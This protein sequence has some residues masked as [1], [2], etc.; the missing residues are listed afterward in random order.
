MMLLHSM[1]DFLEIVLFFLIG[2]EVGKS[3]A[4]FLYMGVKAFFRRVYLSWRMIDTLR[5]FVN[6]VTV[7][8]VSLAMDYF[9]ENEIDD[10]GLL[11]NYKD[12][13]YLV[14]NTGDEEVNLDGISINLRKRVN[15]QLQ[16]FI[17]EARQIIEDGDGQLLMRFLMIR[18]CNKAERRLQAIQ[19]LLDKKNLKGEMA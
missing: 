17:D 6:R 5:G 1:L 8:H 18:Y 2:F 15:E 12:V 3:L 9:K 11:V 13:S 7:L 14:K 10:E 4:R 16:P 19:S